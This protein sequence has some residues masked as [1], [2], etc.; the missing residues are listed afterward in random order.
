MTITHKKKL[1][2]KRITSALVGTLMVATIPIVAGAKDIT[3]PTQPT[4]GWYHSSDTVQQA[5]GLSSKIADSID[6]SNVLSFIDINANMTNVKTQAQLKSALAKSGNKKIRLMANITLTSNIAVNSKSKNII[7]TNGY[8]LNNVS[9]LQGNNKTLNFYCDVENESDF[10]KAL[11]FN[12][13]NYNT[14]II[15]RKAVTLSNKKYSINNARTS[16]YLNNQNLSIK[17]GGQ[18]YINDSS[19]EI[20]GGANRTAIKVTGNGKG[21]NK[22]LIEV[23]P[24]KNNIHMRNFNVSASDFYDS[25]VEYNYNDTSLT[26]YNMNITSAKTGS[27]AVWFNGSSGKSIS[28]IKITNVNI[29]SKGSGVKGNYTSKLL[30]CASDPNARQYVAVKNSIHF[31]NS[32]YLK[33]GVSSAGSFLCT[34]STKENG[35]YLNNVKNSTVQSVTTASKKDGLILNNCNNIYM[36]RFFATVDSTDSTTV[37]ISNSNIVTFMGESQNKTMSLDKIDCD[38][39]KNVA[40]NNV[41][42]NNCTVTGGSKLKFNNVKFKK[43]S[44]KG[45]SSSKVSEFYF[46][47]TTKFNNGFTFANVTKF[48]SSKEV[49]LT[50]EGSITNGS[51]F[52]FVN[53]MNTGKSNFTLTNCSAFTPESL[54]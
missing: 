26:M 17:E 23:A 48:D 18:I 16:L 22:S 35:I 38:S 13:G 47:G 5:D 32:S 36:P 39:S 52:T 53:M 43:V 49:K 7:Y 46:S 3:Q 19:V 10:N 1:L 4:K 31:T 15:I 28:N 25:A 27:N 11:S 30:V 29:D 50:G 41:D 24:N 8:K 42:T 34:K 37:S 51:Y 45:S 54:K 2:G 6:G 9:K 33:F 40:F 14:R 20:C 44:I 21:N 12:N